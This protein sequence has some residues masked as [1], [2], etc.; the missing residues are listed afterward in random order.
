MNSVQLSLKSHPI[1]VTLYNRTFLLG[2]LVTLYTKIGL[3]VQCTFYGDGS[4]ND[5]IVNNTKDC[6]QGLDQD[7]DQ[8]NYSAKQTN[9]YNRWQC[10][11]E[12][13]LHNIIGVKCDTV[14]TRKRRLT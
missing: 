2:N 11:F 12:E 9:K 13:I 5:F 8:N 1:W 6:K 14:S 4:R 3:Y 10:D 7:E